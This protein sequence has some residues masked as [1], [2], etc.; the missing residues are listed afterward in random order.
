MSAS[1]PDP[2]PGDLAATLLA[3]SIATDAASEALP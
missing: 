1:T 3:C 2:L